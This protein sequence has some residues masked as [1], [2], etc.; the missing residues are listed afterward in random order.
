MLKSVLLMS[1]G[2]HVLTIW[3]YNI[4]HKTPHCSC[5]TSVIENADFI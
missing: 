3:R 1:S 4:V 2:K 5:L